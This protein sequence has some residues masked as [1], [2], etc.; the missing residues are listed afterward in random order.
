MNPLAR[1][2]PETV[3]HIF[4]THSEDAFHATQDELDRLNEESVRTYFSRIGRAN[5]SLSSSLHEMN[6]DLR[7]YLPS[8]TVPSVSAPHSD[9]RG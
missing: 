1:R 9:K 3:F 7:S 5:E 2:Y 4:D 8:Y 6:N